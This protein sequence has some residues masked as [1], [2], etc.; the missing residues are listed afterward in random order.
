MLLGEELAAFRDTHGRVGLLAVNCPHRGAPLFY[1][2]NEEGGLRC[3]YHGWKFD[4]EGNCLDMPNEPAESNFKQKIQHTAYPCVERAGV[5]WAY[6]G[7]VKP[8]P[9]LPELEWTAVPDNQRFESKRLQYCNWAQALEGDI[10]QSHVS[11]VHRRIDQPVNQGRG[12]EQVDRIRAADTHPR[13]EVVETDYGVLIGAGRSADTD[14]I[15]WRITQFLMPFWTMTGPYGENP[16]RQT[17]AWVPMD[18]ERTMLFSVT[19]HPLRPLTGKE[20]S[21]MREGGGAGYVGEANF[22]PPTSEP[23]GAWR[24][25]VGKQNDYLW[26]RELQRNKFYSGIPDFWAQDAAMQEGM[27]AIYDRTREHLGTSDLGIIRVRQRLLEAARALCERGVT[28]PA[29]LE[30]ALYRV[31]GAAV[32]LPRGATWLEATKEHRMAV[33]GVNPAGV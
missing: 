30:P 11:F 4:I 17:R 14:G 33:P 15:Y 18:D 23:G 31:R 21:K 1:G 20:I 7:S 24:P 29:A 27:G 19:F 28:P 9:P 2:R 5:I 22:L 26:D 8:P 3:V 10:D 12:H 16:I 13:F 25:K 32:L 6:M